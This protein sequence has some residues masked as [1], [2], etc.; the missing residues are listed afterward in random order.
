MNKLQGQNK[1]LYTLD[2]KERYANVSKYN[3]DCPFQWSPKGTYMILIK[4][5]KVDFIGGSNMQPILTINEPKVETVIFSPCER[6]LVLYQPKNENPYR[7]W[8]FTTNEKIKDFEQS[9]G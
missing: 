6:Y 7:I 5:D 8:N 2:D 9:I 1:V 3:S 4:S